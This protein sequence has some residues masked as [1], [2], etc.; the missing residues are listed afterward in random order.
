MAGV[1]RVL[2]LHVEDAVDDGRRVTLRIRG[3]PHGRQGRRVEG[4]VQAALQ[5]QLAARGAAVDLRDHQAGGRAGGEVGRAGR[6]RRGRRREPRGEGPGHGAGE[7]IAREVADRRG[8]PGL[9]DGAPVEGDDR[10]EDR[11]EVDGIVGHDGRNGR[12]AVGRHGEGRGGQGRRVDRLA[13]GR[14]HQAAGEDA[15]RARGGHRRLDVGGVR[16]AGR[17]VND[18]T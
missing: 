4:V 8:E 6:A 13:E 2:F 14:G 3:V 9:V 12:A 11:A 16:S 1:V 15:D 5:A 18:Q 10:V 17:V 7:R